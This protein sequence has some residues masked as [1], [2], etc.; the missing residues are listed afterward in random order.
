M[1]DFQKRAIGN[2]ESRHRDKIREN[3]EQ[4]LEYAGYILQALDNPGRWSVASHY[5]GDVLADAQAIVTR[6]AMLEAMSDVTG[7]MAS[8]EA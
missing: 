3:A 1:D 4:I 2:H 5:A 6:F 7:I 8:T